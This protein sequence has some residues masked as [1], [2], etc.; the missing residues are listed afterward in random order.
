MVLGLDSITLTVTGGIVTAVEEVVAQDTPDPLA[1]ANAKI[2][3][4]EAQ[5]AEKTTLVA[6]KETVLNETKDEFLALAKKVE[7]FEA[8]FVT[9]QNF[10]A[11]GGQSQGK[12]EPTGSTETPTQIV[13]RRRAE[14][15]AKK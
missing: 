4:L 10:Q 9:G 5:L 3:E 7:K 8:T 14:K 11:N 6:E 12:E 1:V 13:A 2:A 15:D